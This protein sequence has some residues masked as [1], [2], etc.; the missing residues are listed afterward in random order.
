M[1]KVETIVVGAGV[2]G[3]AIARALALQGQEVLILEAAGN[4][5]SVTTARNSGVIHAGIYYAAGS[6]KAQH[7]VRGRDQL[8]A[9][10]QERA[11]PHRRCGKLI[12][13][14]NAAQTRKLEEIQA[15]AVANGV[16]DLQWLD[17]A[18]VHAREPEVVGVAGLFSPST[19][20]VDVHELIHSYLGDAENAGAMLA[21]HSPVSHI[22]HDESRFT[23]TV[24]GNAPTTLACDKLVNAAGLGA[25]ALAR[26][27]DGL[28]AASVPPSYM[29]RGNYFALQGKQPFHHLVYPVPE[30]GGLGVHATLD[31]AGK[32]K[33]GPDVEWVETE[34]Y[35]VNPARAAHFYAAIR[36]YWPGL[37]DD[38]LQP[39]YAGIRPKTTAPGQGDTDFV[40]HGPA[41]H[42]VPNLVN[43]YGIESPGLT[44]ALSIAETV[45]G[46]FAAA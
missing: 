42:G 31:L 12:V 45:A 8:Y 1:D 30:P 38:A 6:R 15:R 36:S 28:P 10:L 43:L 46:H 5:G 16:H 39:D 29:A 22:R 26:H 20:I 37:P 34:D 27:T 32:V 40:I 18:A 41:D 19:G 11:L 24:G 9:Y 14:T 35:T 7:C 2:V 13:A 4:I 33:F 3:L 23:V 21:L 44:S 25:Q 17:A